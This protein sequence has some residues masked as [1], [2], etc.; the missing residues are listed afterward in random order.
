MNAET[1]EVIIEDRIKP[2]DWAELEPNQT[3]EQKRTELEYAVRRFIYDGGIIQQIPMGATSVPDGLMVFPLRQTLVSQKEITQRDEKRQAKVMDRLTRDG[4]A[5]AAMNIHLNSA[6]STVALCQL[7]DCTND[8]LQRLIRDH[9]PTDPRAVRFTS[10]SRDDRTAALVAKVQEALRAGHVGIYAVAEY[11]GISASSIR[12]LVR[13][14]GVNVGRGQVQSCCGGFL[15][16]D[17]MNCPRCG[18]LTN[19]GKRKINETE[20]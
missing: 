7:L 9:F 5:V 1:E 4:K 6:S 16:K 11:C 3:T 13:N 8:R 2:D 15:K 14:H 20:P 10:R 12:D 18:A 17:A 19:N